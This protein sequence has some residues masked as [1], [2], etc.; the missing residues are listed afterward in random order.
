MES[1]QALKQPTTVLS[2]CNQDPLRLE[3]LSNYYEGSSFLLFVPP[4]TLSTVGVD[5][6]QWSSKLGLIT[7][8]VMLFHCLGSSA[9]PLKLR[10]GADPPTA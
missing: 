2:F 3:M 4:P 6:R 10:S 9:L 5:S 7:V 1:I 8:I